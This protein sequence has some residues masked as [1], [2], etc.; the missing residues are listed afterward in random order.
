M[1][2]IEKLYKRENATIQKSISIECELYDKLKII[3]QSKYDATISQIINVCI[4][5]L[6]R[7]QN[8]KYYKKPQWEIMTYRSIM[9]RYENLQELKNI[10]DEKGISIT[11]LINLSIKEFLDKQKEEE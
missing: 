1:N 3:A 8:I 7:S 9:I 11:R 2:P 10:K 6:L 5:E 4:E